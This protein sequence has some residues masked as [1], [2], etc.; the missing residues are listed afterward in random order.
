MKAR[1]TALRCDLSVLCVN[2]VTPNYRNAVT[3]SQWIDGLSGSLVVNYRFKCAQ[4]GC[5]KNHSETDHLFHLSVSHLSGLS[6]PHSSRTVTASSRETR[7]FLLP[8]VSRPQSA[9]RLWSVESWATRSSL[10]AD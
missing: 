7:F 3:M 6:R 10:L 2:K 4:D 1:E 5:C 9:Q 8:A